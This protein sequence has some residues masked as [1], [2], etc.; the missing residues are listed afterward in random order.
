MG[1]S[2]SVFARA[3]GGLATTLTVT[4]VCALTLIGG[5][6][7][8]NVWSAGYIRA[9]PDA[10]L[11]RD[12]RIN[13]N[14]RA[15]RLTMI[16]HDRIVEWYDLEKPDDLAGL[17]DEYFATG[18]EFESYVHFRSKLFEGRFYGV[19][20]DGYRRTRADAPWPPAPENLNVFFFGGST[21]FGVGPYW[22]TVAAYLE[23]ELARDAARPVRVYNFGRSGYQSSQELILLSRL[24]SSGARPDLAVFMDGL[25]D[26]CFTDGPSGWQ[27][28]QS[29][30]NATAST[31]LSRAAGRE[32]QVPWRL[33][34]E[35]FAGMPA[36]RL[37]NAKLARMNEP[38]L[39][40]YRGPA[41]AVPEPDPPREVIDA[42]IRQYL[43]NARQAEG[44][45]A[46]F[47][48][49]AHFV[50]QPIPTY[51]YDPRH[52][53]F[54]PTQIGCH[55]GSRAGYPVMREIWEAGRLDLKNFVWAAD[56]QATATE[57]LY[58][59]A[60]HYTAPFSRTIARFIADDLRARGLPRGQGGRS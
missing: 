40:A 6:T 57:N 1:S 28:L 8:L 12:E 2:R 46:K 32:P 29:Y 51:R 9:N 14:T 26:F 33:L 25:N 41:E 13:E 5:F 58:I 27:A 55:T 43:N 50:W 60:F 47:G 11:S 24:L 4:A 44:L 39:P 35:F 56:L 18:A 31:A 10:L 21:S 22:G 49:D 38:P 42:T 30:F 20:K 23:A 15:H 34:T 7:A 59:D 19:T 45:G 48:F 52:H 36:L 53:L 37:A 54:Y 3:L 17:W 16:P